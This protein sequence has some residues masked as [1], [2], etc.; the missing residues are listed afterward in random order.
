MA[1]DVVHPQAE[2]ITDLRAGN[3]NGD[4]VGET[5]HDGARKELHRR[6]HAGD[7]QQD[8]QDPSHHRAGKQAIDSVPRDDARD[9]NHK[10]A[11][12]SA[13]LRL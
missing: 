11:R 6:A 12:G 4:A 3:E 13:N 5:D 7:A 1:G 10:R 9:H 8:E 2:K